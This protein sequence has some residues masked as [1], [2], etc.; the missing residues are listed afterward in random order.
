MEY[1]LMPKIDQY[2]DNKALEMQKVQASLNSSEVKTKE[3]LE[4]V[5][6]ESIS[7][8]KEASDVK[9][10]QNVKTASPKYEVV[11][12]NTNFGYNDSSKDFYVKVERGNVENQYPTEEMMKM[13]AYM[14]SLSEEA[15][16]TAS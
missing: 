1:G 2:S 7:K 10:A 3:G 13:K 8:A 4:Q 9:A 6:Q 15:A 11:L 14:L 5:Q 12:S 16:V